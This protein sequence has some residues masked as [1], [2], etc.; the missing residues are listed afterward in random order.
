[1]FHLIQQ[2]DLGTAESVL[3]DWDNTYKR[4]CAYWHSI[5]FV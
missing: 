1:M 5:Y 2:L 4:R 3:E